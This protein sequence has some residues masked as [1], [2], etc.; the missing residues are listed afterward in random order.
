MLEVVKIIK[1]FPE[2]HQVVKYFLHFYLFVYIPQQQPWGANEPLHFLF[3]QSVA[4][5]T[6]ASR[7]PVEHINFMTFEIQWTLRR[8][9]LIRKIGQYLSLVTFSTSC[10]HK[11]FYFF[12][13]TCEINRLNSKKLAILITACRHVTTSLS[14]ALVND[15]FVQRVIVVCTFFYYQKHRRV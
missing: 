7:Q 9:G 15:I 11:L 5:L 12:L 6:H 2:N 3:S 13:L 4:I 8:E 10:Y 14:N 1:K